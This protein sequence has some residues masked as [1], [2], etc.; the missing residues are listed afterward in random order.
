MEWVF[1]FDQSPHDVTV[2]ATGEALAPEFDQLFEA[3]CA[4]ERF[5]PRMLVLLD[6]CDVDLE[7]VPQMEL[8]RVSDGLATF[9]EKCEGCALA[10]VA[11]QPLAASMI[12]GVD[13]GG[14]AKWMR[15]WVAC[16]VDEAVIWLE[17]QLALRA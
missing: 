1:E 2:T 10:V 7:R 11:T 6:L 12:R 8:E 16:T 15:V 13:F 17:S 9:R 5:E 14:H 4:D 3:L